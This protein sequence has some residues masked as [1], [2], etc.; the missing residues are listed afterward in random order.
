MKTSPLRPEGTRPYSKPQEAQE[1]QAFQQQ[2]AAEAYC[3][4]PPVPLDWPRGLRSE[5]LVLG[6]GQ[7]DDCT[8]KGIQGKQKCGANRCRGVQY[9]PRRTVNTDGNETWRGPALEPA[10]ATLVS[11]LL[12]LQPALRPRERVTPCAVVLFGIHVAA[13]DRREVVVTAGVRFEAMAVVAQIRRR[14]LQAV[15]QT[16]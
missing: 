12:R 3:R 1:A 14:L 5:T 4:S 16:L 2:K 15:A 7:C 11:S 8:G 9:L 13:V 6:Y 10:P